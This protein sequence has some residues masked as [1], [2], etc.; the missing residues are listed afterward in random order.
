MKLT[1][2]DLEFSMF[3]GIYP[4]EKTKMAKVSFT[5]EISL[6]TVLKA[7]NELSYLVNYDDIILL[8][9]NNFEGE[10]YDLIEDVIFAAA[11]LLNGK[12]PNV[13]ELNVKVKKFGTHEFINFVAIEKTFTRDFFI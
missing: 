2:E 6:E 3:L 13:L 8:I 11:K 9:K 4:K 12:I 5:F 10:N 1:I 7:K